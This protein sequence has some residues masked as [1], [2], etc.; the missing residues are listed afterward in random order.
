M[1]KL[2]IQQKIEDLKMEY[3]RIQGDME[4][5]ESTGHSIEKL[6]EKLSFIEEELSTYRSALKKH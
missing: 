3:S 2:D 6:E 1:N 5:L 4:K